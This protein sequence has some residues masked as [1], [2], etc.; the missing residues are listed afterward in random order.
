MPRFDLGPFTSQMASDQL[1]NFFMP[2]FV[3]HLQI[4]LCPC[5]VVLADLPG[6]LRLNTILSL[7]LPLSNT[8][9]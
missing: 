2:S 1:P 6:P 9:S 5:V 4:S 3:Y 8:T 7:A